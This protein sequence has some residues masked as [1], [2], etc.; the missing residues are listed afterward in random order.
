MN[1]YFQQFEK[2]GLQVFL[3]GAKYNFRTSTMGEA[4][5]SEQINHALDDGNFDFQT[6]YTGEQIHGG[7]VSYPLEEKTNSFAVGEIIPQS[8]GLITDQ[9]KQVLMVKFA[10]CTP[11]IIYDARQKVVSIVHSGW[12]STVQR[13]SQLAVKRMQDQFYSKKE[14]LLVYIGP[15]IDQ[16]NYE[17]GEEVYQAFNE[18]EDQSTFI[19]AGVKAGKYQLSMIDANLYLIKELGINE[20]KIMVDR[21]S[22]YLSSELHSARKEGKNYQLNGLFAMIK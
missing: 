11:I 20:E 18:W 13:I 4:A 10:D 8:D 5:V 16:D 7:K 9:P 14:D 21:R 1:N 6:F 3:A 22:T 19:K 17:V 12:R 15:S 2:M